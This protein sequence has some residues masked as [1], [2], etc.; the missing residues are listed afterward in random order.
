[1]TT[2]GKT[3]TDNLD[4]KLRTKLDRLNI[5]GIKHHIFLCCDQ[6]KANCCDVEQGIASWEFLKNRLQELNL[7]DRGGVYRSKANCL[8]VC[9]RGPIAVV[10][11]DGIWYHSCTPEVLEQIIQQHLICGEPVE[12]YMLAKVENED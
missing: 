2:K 6:S 8:R 1:M 4:E 11:P 3:V 12:E 7:S 10:Y 9:S 5:T